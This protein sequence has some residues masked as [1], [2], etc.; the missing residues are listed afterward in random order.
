MPAYRNA[1][2]GTA[3]TSGDSPQ[4]M[5]YGIVLLLWQIWPRVGRC[6]QLD[7]K[8]PFMLPGWSA[9]KIGDHYAV[10]SPR[11]A[12]ERLRAGNGNWSGMEGQPPGSV[13]NSDPRRQCISHHRP[14]EDACMDP[15]SDGNSRPPVDPPSPGT[16][17][18]AGTSTGLSPS[19]WRPRPTLL[20]SSPSV[21]RPRPTLLEMS[22]LEWRPRPTLLKSSLPVW[23][24]W[25]TLLKSSPS[26]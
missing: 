15:T 7:V 14:Y 16:C 21:W 5:V 11:L 3:T 18:T 19:V 24:P 13:I 25:R 1:D 10:I 23:R 4:G 12:A 17:W 22:P 9:E 8:F 26:V 20:R 6:P 2:T